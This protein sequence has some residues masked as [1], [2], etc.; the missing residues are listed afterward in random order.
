M[1][2]RASFH[3]LLWMPF[4]LADCPLVTADAEGPTCDE[5]RL[6]LRRAVA[7]FRTRAGTEGGY[8][9]RVAAD[10]S[11]RAGEE[12][13]GP[14][15]AWIEPPGTPAVGQAYLDAFDAC[16]DEELLAAAVETGLA[17]VR[18]QLESGGWGERI[19]FA[20][21]DRR[22]FAYRVDGGEVGSRDNTT[23]FDDDKSQSCLRFLLALAARLERRQPV[24]AA[25]PRIR[26]A[27]TYALEAFARAQFPIG[28]WPQKWRGSRGKT[29]RLGPDADGGFPRARIPTDWPR[30]WSKAGYS[31]LYTL[32]DG[33]MSDMIS[34]LLVA[35]ETTGDDRW[36]EIARRGGD[37]LLRAQLP[38]PQPAWAQQ[39][40]RS[41]RPAWARRFEPPAVSGG[42]SQGVLLTLIRLAR[43][44]GE[45]R[46]LA[47]VQPAVDYL[48]RSRLSDGRLARFY[49][50]GTNRPLYM[51]RD[52]ELTHDD[53]DLPTHY[54]FKVDARLDAIEWAAAAVHAP[55]PE[56]KSPN[57]AKLRRRAAELLAT[58]DDRGGWVEQGSLPGVDGRTAVI[59]SRTFIRNLGTLASLI[60]AFDRDERR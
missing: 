11:R 35:H 9:H 38:E 8:V 27:A 17:L 6:G 54:G 59:D 52:Y 48:R 40:D 25:A 32:N 57:A 50:L 39:Y 7:F 56:T 12:A 1:G 3:W 22:A 44:T 53:S 15:T 43:V 10:L 31:D 60:G 49:E 5:A 42:E 19:E 21:A 41:M 29:D 4:L 14:T 47:P 24:P 37:F 18:G 51:T 23:T 46:Y 36:L 55:G 34:T 2:P 26:E 45:D 20:P 30:T 33:L 13:V 16:G 58:L 28:G